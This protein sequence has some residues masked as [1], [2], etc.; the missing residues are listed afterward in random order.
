MAFHDAPT[1]EDLPPSHLGEWIPE[2][3]RDRT[4]EPSEAGDTALTTWLDGYQPTLEPMEALLEPK[5]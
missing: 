3:D 2:D 5:E 1:P 4:D